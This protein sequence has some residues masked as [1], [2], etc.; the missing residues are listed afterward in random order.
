MSK[1]ELQSKSGKEARKARIYFGGSTNAVR[2]SSRLNTPRFYPLL[3]VPRFL[4]IP[5]SFS[6]DQIA[7][8]QKCFNELGLIILH[9]VHKDDG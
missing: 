6:W 4:I 3:N 9:G 7:S 5:F 2:V 8:G 1:I